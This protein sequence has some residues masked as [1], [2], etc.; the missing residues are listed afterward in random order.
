MKKYLFVLGVSILFIAGCSSNSN[1]DEVSKLEKTISSLKKENSELDKKVT[2]FESLLNE[3]G[4]NSDSSSESYNN[5]NSSTFP[6]NE[7]LEFESGEIVTVQSI[8]DN[9]ELQLHETTEGEH[10]VVVTAII[11]NAGSSPLRINSQNFSLYDNNSEIARFD[12][13]TYSNNIPNDIAAGMKATLVI[14]FSA[15][16]N[17]PYSVTFGDAIWKQ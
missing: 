10:P 1:S 15:K 13:S 7:S 6:L 8:E 3:F 16:G 11:E 12:A 9:P 5:S 17:A 14:H 2:A 4:G